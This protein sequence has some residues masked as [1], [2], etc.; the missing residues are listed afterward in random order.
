M[1]TDTSCIYFI[2]VN[3]VVFLL[4]RCVCLGPEVNGGPRRIFVTNYILSAAANELTTLLLLYCTSKL[5]V[6]DVHE[7]MLF[8]IEYHLKVIELIL[9][10]STL[11]HYGVYKALNNYRQ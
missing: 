7:V 11:N 6:Y 2:S 8:L 9:L 1:K 10:I 4:T 5:I 3:I